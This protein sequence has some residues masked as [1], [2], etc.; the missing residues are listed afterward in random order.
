MRTLLRSSMIMVFLG[1]FSLAAP[2]SG[3]DGPAKVKK[4]KK[5]PYK[6]FKFVISFGGKPI[7]GCNKISGLPANAEVAKKKG[8]GK[9]LIMQEC[10]FK[11]KSILGKIVRNKK[12][13]E[14]IDLGVSS[15][16]SWILHGCSPQEWKVNGFDGK[17]ND[18]LTEE[19]VI[20]MEWFD[21]N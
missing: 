20:V 14:T 15:G 2:A 5:D 12:E 1:V 7:G 3:G 19:M 16:K 18:I 10:S 11:K 4:A 6:N 8:K 13:P 9:K 17:G 21:V